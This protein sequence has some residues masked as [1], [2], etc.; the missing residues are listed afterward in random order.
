LKSDKRLT[1]RNADQ[2]GFIATMRFNHLQPPFDN[3]AM[4]RALL[5]AVSQ[6]DYMIG[7]V[8]TDPAL[9]RAGCGY[10]TPGTPMASEAGLE[11]LTGPRDLAKVKRALAEAGYQGE[12]IAL[13]APTNIASAKAL[14][15]I[16]NDLMKQLGLAIDYQAMDWATLVQRRTKKEP[17]DQGGWSLYHTSWS[18]NDHLNP[19]GHV[20][21]RGNGPEA[22]VGWPTAPKLEA[23][24]EAWLAA[25]DLA[26]QKS[27][28]AE[29]QRQAF[30]DV[31][32]IPLGQYF[33]PTAYQ[34]N[35]QGVLSGNPVFWN[36]RRA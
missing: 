3:P 13:L 31:P 11:A 36:V 19:V 17:L 30:E 7:M 12:R 14:A 26:A 5:G 24:R 25:P 4:R 6:P 16:T 10:F 2:A 29:L 33:A 22:T 15:D 9:W 34:A 18:G 20:F 27:L 28:A 8:G 21:L 32:Y 35:L 23:L 1:V